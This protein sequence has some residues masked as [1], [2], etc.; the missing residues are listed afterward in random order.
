MVAG[1]P[2]TSFEV[3]DGLFRKK[4]KAT[5]GT[6]QSPTKSTPD[7]AGITLPDTTTDATENN[8]SSYFDEKEN[9]KNLRYDNRTKKLNAFT[10]RIGNMFKKFDKPEMAYGGVPKYQKGDEVSL[11]TSN[12]F[13]EEEQSILNAGKRNNYGQVEIPDYSQSPT[14]QAQQGFDDYFSPEKSIERQAELF[15]GQGTA[16]IIPEATNPDDYT[17]EGKIK[18]SWEID[19]GQVWDNVNYAARSITGGLDEN[20]KKRNHF[21]QIYGWDPNRQTDDRFRGNYATNQV[22][23]A[24]NFRDPQGGQMEYSQEGGQYNVGEEVEMT[25]QEIAKFVA[26]GGKLKYV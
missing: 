24:T 12:P 6:P 4:Y 18:Q 19:P 9:N 26:G 23:A 5:W 14:M 21:A 13:E 22:A 7:S 8:L 16:K 10:G 2:L 20:Y 3:N 15:T 25:A 17:T 11:Y 1:Q